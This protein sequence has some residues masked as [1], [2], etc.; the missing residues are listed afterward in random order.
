[1]D[2]ISSPVL[3]FFKSTTR[4]ILPVSSRF[5]LSLSVNLCTKNSKCKLGSFLM[6]CIPT[7]P[8]PSSACCKDKRAL[9]RRISEERREGKECVSTCR[10]RWS[11]DHKK[12]KKDNKKRAQ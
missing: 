9:V 6:P 7:T 1:M 10:S 2:G 12:K 3:E 11:R 5:F 8:F 4:P